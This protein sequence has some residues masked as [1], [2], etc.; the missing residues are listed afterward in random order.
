VCVKVGSVIKED[1]GYGDG[2]GKNYG[3]AT[4]LAAKE[5]VSDAMKRC[6][7]MFGDPFGLV[8]YEK[9]PAQKEG[10]IKTRMSS[11]KAKE[12]GKHTELLDMMNACASVADLHE[13]WQ[14][15]IIPRLRWL[16]RKWF[17]PMRDHYEKTLEAIEAK[18]G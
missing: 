5:A 3:E 6:L 17:V 7:R 8:L 1:V 13:C 2:F 15:E 12:E 9:N 18:E 10:R 4:E 16:P 11:A 14:D